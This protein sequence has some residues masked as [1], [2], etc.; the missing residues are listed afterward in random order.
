MHRQGLLGSLLIKLNAAAAVYRR[1]SIL[2]DY[3]IVEVVGFTAITAAVSYLVC[4]NE[5]L[6]STPYVERLRLMV[7]IGR[8]SPSTR[9]GACGEPIPRVRPCEAGLPWTLQVCQPAS[10]RS[11]SLLD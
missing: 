6:M 8:V 10:R 11:V 5:P 7:I 4:L 9:V 1:H 2:H 3:P